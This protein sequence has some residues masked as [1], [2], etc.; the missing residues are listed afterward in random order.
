MFHKVWEFEGFQTAKVAIKVIQ[1]HWQW[2]HS[3]GHITIPISVP[4]QLCLYNAQ[5]TKYYHLFELFPKISR[6]H[7]TLNI[8]LLGVV[9]H[10]C[11]STPLYVLV[12]EIWN[13]HF[14][15]TKDMIGGTFFKRVTWPWP[16][17]LGVVCLLKASIWYIPPVYKIWWLTLQPFRRYNCGRK[18]W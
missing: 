14:T 4:L 17:P 16:R 13:A 2:R 11:T 18:N 5:L 8:S 15:D 10:T 12:H 3:I 7:M 6:G 1:E 9:H